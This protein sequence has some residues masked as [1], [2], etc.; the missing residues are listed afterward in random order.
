MTVPSEAHHTDTF[1]TADPGF[2]KSDR[3]AMR[4]YLQRTEVRLS[5]L[6]RIATAFI[7]GAGL[8]I[9][10][11]IFFREEIV[12]VMGVFIEMWFS[13]FPV[14]ESWGGAVQVILSVLVI[15][16]FILS[17]GIPLYAFFLLVKDVIHFY[18]SIYT[19]GFPRELFTPSFALTGIGFS[20]DE[21]ETVK[22]RVMQYQYSPTTIDFMIPFSGQKREI[23]FDETIYNTNGAIIPRSRQ[24]DDLLEKGML[25]RDAD[26]LNVERFNAAFGLARTVDRRLHEEVATQEAS[27]VRHVL[28]L[29]RL[30]LRYIATLLTFIWTALVTFIMLPFLHE[31]RIPGLV[32]LSVGYLVWSI[33]VMPILRLPLTWIYRHKHG[34]P[35]KTHIDRQLTT[36]QTEVEKFCYAAI[37]CSALGLIVSLGVYTR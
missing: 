5:T 1:A 26:K 32:V 29:R 34:M 35:K 9:L 20:P 7:N 19:P 14:T 36:L 37:A 12:V 23:Y 10:F 4:A 27:L 11:P 2:E 6:H 33:L 13:P 15:F 25:P 17:I 21:S 18:F 30:V 31:E 22:R 28:Y 3:E 24:Y 8:L 16:P